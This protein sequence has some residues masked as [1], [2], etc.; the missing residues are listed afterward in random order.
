MLSRERLTRHR[1]D[2]DG[3]PQRDGIVP[4]ANTAFFTPEHQNGTLKFGTGCRP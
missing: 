4:T 1:A 3:L 2:R